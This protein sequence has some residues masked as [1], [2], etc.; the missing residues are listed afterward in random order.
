[1]NT[2]LK[3]YS[4]FLLIFTFQL[5]MGSE[6]APCP[7]SSCSGMVNDLRKWVLKLEELVRH[8]SDEISKLEKITRD[9]ASSDRDELRQWM[10][11][12]MDCASKAVDLSKKT[13]K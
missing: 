6:G 9:C 5:T 7:C 12:A 2:S 1:M 8:K 4:L 13:S 3:K 10:K 11:A